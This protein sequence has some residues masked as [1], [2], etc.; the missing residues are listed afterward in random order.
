MLSFGEAF[1]ELL[2]LTSSAFNSATPSLESQ[3]FVAVKVLAVFLGDAIEHNITG[4][5]SST[6]EL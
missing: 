3:A 2:V 5:S 1:E 6:C 4:N